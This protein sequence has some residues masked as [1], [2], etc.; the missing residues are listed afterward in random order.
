MQPSQLSV[1][2]DEIAK[3]EAMAEEWWDPNGK[4][5]P[6]HMLNPCRLDYIIEMIRTEFACNPAKVK[7]FSEL[8]ILDIGCGGGLLAEP[9]AR[10][11]ASVTGIDVTDAAIIAA[12][13]HAK[14]MQV[15]IIYL[16]EIYLP[17]TICISVQIKMFLHIRGLEELLVR[18]IRACS[19]FL[20]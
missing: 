5:K 6:L 13:A 20:L 7:P 12:K 16:K 4:F 17:T 19:S 18:P 10:L 3:F 15:S 2:P 11:G 14:T 8:T 9:M 1:D